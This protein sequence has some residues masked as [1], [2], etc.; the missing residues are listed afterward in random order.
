MV[1]SMLLREPRSASTQDEVAT[2]RHF[3]PTCGLI[4]LVTGALDRAPSADRTA[5]VASTKFTLTMAALLIQT[6]P[7]WWT[8]RTCPRSSGRCAWSCQ[9]SV[10]CGCRSLESSGRSH[11]RSWPSLAD[12]VAFE[13]AGIER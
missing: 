6:P 3:L 8:C 1:E 2:C 5:T 13:A 4:R 11:A 9:R 7:P 10:R 12:D